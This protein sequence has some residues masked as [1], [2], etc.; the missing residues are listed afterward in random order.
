MASVDNEYGLKTIGDGAFNGCYELTKIEIPN[1]VT[2]IGMR[3]F[4]DCG[5]NNVVIPDSVIEIG[6]QAFNNCGEESVYIGKSVQL[7]EDD[8]FDTNPEDLS[9]I[10]IHPENVNVKI[11]N[12]CLINIDKYN[13]I[14]L[15]KGCNR[16]VIPEEVE[17]ILSAAFQMCNGLVNI[18]IPDNVGYVWGD[19]FWH[20]EN[21]TTLKLGKGVSIIASGLLFQGFFPYCD[22]LTNIEIDADNTY[23]RVEDGCVIENVAN[24]LVFCKKVSEIVVPNSVIEIGSDAFMGNRVLTKLTIPSSV[25]KIRRGAF[26]M[27]DNL[28]QVVFEIKTGWNVGTSEILEEELASPEDAAIYL[29]ENSYYNDWILS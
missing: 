9:N 2:K 16:S 17:S 8:A 6:I 19:I 28:A 20:C 11:E 26:F 12:Y 7:I 23:F 25:T 22:K 5:I 24:R 18:E 14:N 10:T 4:Q 21:L 13:R 3:A 27:C 1:T 15:V 29:I